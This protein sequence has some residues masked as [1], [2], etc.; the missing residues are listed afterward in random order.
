MMKK[1]YEITGTTKHGYK[2]KRKVV[3]ESSK[4]AK[5]LARLLGV[6]KVTSVYEV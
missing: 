2:D 1:T 3:A 6:V 5:A 4:D